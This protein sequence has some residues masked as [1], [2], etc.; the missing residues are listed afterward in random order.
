MPGLTA[1]PEVRVIHQPGYGAQ[2]PETIIPENNDTETSTGFNAQLISAEMIDGRLS[3]NP[4]EQ[5]IPLRVPA[6]TCIQ[7]SPEQ[8][9]L[10]DGD[11]VYVESRQAEVFYTGGM[12]PG[13]QHLLPRDYDVDIFEAM[14]IA[15]Y[16]YGSTGNSG[17]NGLLSITGV[18]PTD[19]YIMRKTSD[20]CEITIRVDLE[21][22]ANDMCDRLV[23]QAGDKLL[24][25]YSPKEE[26]TNFGMFTFF[27]F[28]I[29]QLFRQ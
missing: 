21:D 27:T 19:L 3:C 8:T 22:A 11:I 10:R 18:V 12:L 1:K 2:F 15:G 17:G 24:L 14:A 4:N 23:V 25:R 29:Q 6:G 9:I 26:V 5:I 16:S 28:G 20:G 7:L 13:G